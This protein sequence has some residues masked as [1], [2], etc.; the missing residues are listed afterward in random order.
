M[1]SVEQL[2]LEQIYVIPGPQKDILQLH[3]IFCEKL[4]KF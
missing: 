4:R 1:L 2:S 3:W